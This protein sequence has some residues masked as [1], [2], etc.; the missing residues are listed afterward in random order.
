[1]LN[2]HIFLYSVQMV[3]SQNSLTDQYSFLLV[4]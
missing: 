1:M 4:T 3:Y 2:T